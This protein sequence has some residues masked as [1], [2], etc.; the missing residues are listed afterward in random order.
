MTADFQ[1]TMAK[2]REANLDFVSLITS[3]KKFLGGSG[4]IEINGEIVPTLPSVLQAYR[5]GEMASITLKSGDTEVHLDNASG[6]LKVSDASGNLV[7]VAISKLLFSQIASCVLDE[8]IIASCHIDSIEAR[9]N[10]Q[11]DNLNVTAMSAD[12]FKGR[13]ANMGSATIAKLQAQSAT[14]HS[15]VIRR[16][17]FNPA[18]TADIFSSFNAPYMYSAGNAQFQSEQGLDMWICRRPT[19]AELDAGYKEPSTMGFKALTPNSG[20][21]VNR[22]PD[23]IT[24]Q[25]DTA[26]KQYT[27]RSCDNIANNFPMGLS[28]TGAVTIGDTP[29]AKSFGGNYIDFAHMLGWP[30]KSY[31]ANP[32]DADWV[33]NACKIAQGACFLQA[34]AP[35]DQGK[36]FFIRTLGNAWKIYRRL[37]IK[38]QSG[39]AH[40]AMMDLEYEIPPYTC[41]RL[42]ANA[43]Y[44][45]DISYS[46]LEL[47]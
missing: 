42:R 43:F 20:P 27:G 38:F 25:G 39:I 1:T 17:A 18:D 44:G 47:T 34:I 30:L 12:E 11:I 46:V 37:A 45:G 26:F 29:I 31:I 16:L 6:A 40:E 24:F 5:R 28:A 8:A 7:T 41:L 2:I 3:L 13:Y 9:G 22:L 14:L 35:A 15:A 36:V 10:A 33:P 32:A 19:L 21:I 23:M 4:D